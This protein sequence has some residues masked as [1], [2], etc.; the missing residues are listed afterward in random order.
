MFEDWEFM[1]YFAYAMLIT[2][3]LLYIKIFFE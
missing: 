1:D 3:I 2:L